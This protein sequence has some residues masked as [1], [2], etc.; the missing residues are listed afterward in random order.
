MIQTTSGGNIG[1]GFAVPSDTV[2]LIATRIVNGESLELGYLGISGQAAGDGDVGVVVAEV[3]PESPAEAAG[4]LAGDVIVS[5][6]SEPMHDIFELSAAVKLRLP[7]ES[8]ELTVRRG[9][10]IYIVTAVL[11][12]LG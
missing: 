4:L 9:G 5:I 2:E 10:D 7:G 8:V 12:A 6:D 1:L 3:V 11:D